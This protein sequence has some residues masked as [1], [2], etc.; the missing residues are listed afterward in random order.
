MTVLSGSAH[1]AAGGAAPGPVLIVLLGVVVTAV[2]AQVV[3]CRLGLPA[4]VGVLAAGQVILHYAL[5]FSAPS[6]AGC[7]AR[8][9][10]SAAGHA[11]HNGHGVD[12]GVLASG[13][14]ALCADGGMA[15]AGPA[16][17]GA[18]WW[19]LAAHAVAIVLLAAVLARGERAVWAV[20]GC[21]ARIRARVVVRAVPPVW[22]PRIP[23]ISVDAARPTGRDTYLRVSP[24]RGPPAVHTPCPALLATRTA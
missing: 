13:D 6:A 22:A 1:V 4:L 24:R 11:L 23:Q 18:G 5:G 7:A 19:M 10:S 16:G 17:A 3:R 2:A 20:A 9:G 14:A 15:V 21:W 12:G 8:S